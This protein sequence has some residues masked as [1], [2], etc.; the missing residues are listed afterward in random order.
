VRSRKRHVQQQLFKSH[1]GKRR[2]AGRPPK[3]SR[4]SEPHK[5]RPALSPRFPVHV[6]LRI[7]PDLKCLRTR[8]LFLAIREATL[9]IARRREDFRIIH[10]SIQRDHLHLLVEAAD[11]MALARGMQG[12]A[13]SAAKHVNRAISKHRGT[14]RRGAVFPDRYHSRILK[15]PTSVKHALSYVLNNWRHH[16]QDRDRTWLVDPFSSGVSFPGWRELEGELVMWKPPPSYHALWVWLPTTWLLRSGWPL[17]GPISARDVPG[18]PR[19]ET[20]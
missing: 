9:R 11:R 10:V 7:A 17:A 19:I 20:T 12:F 3:G 8:Q 4:S 5:R 13:G 18:A 6:T 15:S 14:C 2:G 1:G 16:G